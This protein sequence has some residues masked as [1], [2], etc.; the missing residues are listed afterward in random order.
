MPVG[1]EDENI[2]DSS[3]GSQ[4]LQPSLMISYLMMARGSK[5]RGP[6]QEDTKVGGFGI[7]GVRMCRVWGLGLRV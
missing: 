7:L 5:L 2:I 3:H 4:G 1:Q 6:R